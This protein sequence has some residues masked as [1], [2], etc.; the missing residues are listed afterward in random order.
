[1]LRSNRQRGGIFSPARWGYD[2]AER[3]ERNYEQQH[4]NWKVG[5]DSALFEPQIL[6]RAEAR[7]RARAKALVT[8]AEV[9]FRQ[10]TGQNYWRR[11][12]VWIPGVAFLGTDTFESWRRW[13]DFRWR[14]GLHMPLRRRVVSGTE[15]L[16]LVKPPTAHCAADNV[17][18]SGG[19]IPPAPAT[20]PEYRRE[21]GV[22]PL[23]RTTDGRLVGVPVQETLFG[24]MP[25]K[26]GMGKTTEA[27]H[28]FLHLV[29]V[30][31][32]GGLFIDPAGDAVTQ[33]KEYLAAPEVMDRVVEIDLTA[34][35]QLGWNPIAMTRL[36]AEERSHKVR[37]IRDSIAAAMGW[38]TGVNQR[39]LNLVTQAAQ[40]LIELSMQLPP[41]ASPTLYQ[42]L[43]LLSNERWRR[44]VQP[45][46]SGAS[47]DFW[48]N[49]FGALAREAMTPV[50]NLIDDMRG[51]EKLA[52]LL[53]SP[54]STFDMRR[55]MDSRQIVLVTLGPIGSEA[56]LLANFLIYDLVRAAFSRAD[57][58][59]L[60]RNLFWVVLDELQTYDGGVSGNIA[61]ILEQTRK[62]GLRAFG[63]N[64]DPAA[65]EDRTL[66]ALLVNRSHLIATA[67]SYEASQKLVREWGG[68]PDAS[69][70]RRLAKY[71]YLC[72]V[73]LG[74]RTG[75]PRPFLIHGLTVEDMWG[76][77]AAP[78]RLGHLEAAL[79]RNTGR[80]EVADTLRE[81]NDLDDRVL[82]ALGRRVP[83]GAQVAGS[84]RGEVPEIDIPERP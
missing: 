60:Q 64:Q 19:Y 69:T 10:W 39:A 37:A 84:G 40:S 23:G 68:V 41:E 46:L 26:S 56:S 20:L 25:G 16:G 72:D 18:R 12:G 67:N 7:S 59:P 21:R 9:V 62:F 51:S 81:L 73:E 14:T 36:P 5:G 82:E 4:L 65:L 42:I 71:T 63:F 38:H 53:G 22:L 17:E 3:L 49:R 6:I 66:R 24:Y 48:D 79:D 77:I 80:R 83:S 11:A 8:A 55:A 50:T 61:V 45:Y 28:Q 74:A 31:G 70:L 13:F 57:L 29:L 76:D 52:G 1:M 35:R 58:H 78:E 27:M 15:V 54:Y 2:A 32:D 75:R 44:A 47:R 30:E 33:L 43:P 34:P